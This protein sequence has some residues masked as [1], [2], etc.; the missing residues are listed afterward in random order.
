MWKD[1]FKLAGEATGLADGERFFGPIRLSNCRGLTV[2]EIAM[3][4]LSIVAPNG[5]RI[6]TGEKVLEV[7]RWAPGKP[8]RDLFIVE[9]RHYLSE[10]LEEELG[11]AVCIVDVTGY[12]DWQPDELQPDCAS[13]WEP[14]WTAWEI[15]NVRGIAP[16]PVIAKKRLYDIDV[17]VSKTL[18]RIHPTLG[19]V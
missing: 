18:A 15:A 10:S 8:L 17:A 1:R 12:H 14:G 16:F 6:A 7:R 5:T 13:Y 3:T 11:S 19:D 4:A 9:N 2:R